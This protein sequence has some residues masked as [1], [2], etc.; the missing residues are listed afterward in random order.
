[1]DG[2]NRRLLVAARMQIP[3]AAALL[4]AAAAD[5][6]GLARIRISEDQHFVSADSGLRFVPRGFNYDHDSHLRL[7]EDYWSNDWQAV[8]DD[9]AEMKALGANTVRIHLQVERFMDGP[10]EPDLANL[11]RLRDLIA[12]ADRLGLYLDLT[13]LGSYRSRDPSWYARLPEAERWA[14]QAAFWEAVA[15]TGAGH[16]AVLAY[17][18]M[19]EPLVAAT[20]R[21]DGDWV[22]PTALDGL[23]FLQYVNVDP[24][25]RDR[26]DIAVA[27]IR[28]MRE[29]IRRH[30]KEA[31]ITVGQ[32]PLFASVDA[33]G[34]APSRVAREVDYLSVHLY[35][36]SGAVDRML[37]LLRDYAAWGRPVVIEETFPLRSSLEEYRSFL[38]QSRQVAGGWLTFYWGQPQELASSSDRAK[39]AA[40][41]AV[42]AEVLGR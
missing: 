19:N 27:W 11:A 42:F 37:G 12:L 24:A 40:N 17:N 13:G 33:A 36:E 14:A 16:P 35:P 39:Q 32:F 5:A 21:G 18:L 9:F 22:D 4:M 8:Q 30:D 29:A 2:W 15:A 7:I 6:Q 38:M 3:I 26:A 28:R 34:F 31:L 41:L 25:G 10:N 1:M 23:H 20:K